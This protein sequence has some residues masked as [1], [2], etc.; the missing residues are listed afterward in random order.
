MLALVDGARDR[1]VDFSYDTYPYPAGST[2]LFI[3]LP[4]W[5]HDGGPE[6]LLQRLSS[7][8]DRNRLLDEMREPGSPYALWP[9]D[10]VRISSVSSDRNRWMEGLFLNEIAEKVGKD[11]DEQALDMLVQENLGISA[12]V[13]RGSEPDLQEMMRHPSQMCST[14]ALLMGSH[15]HPRGYG[16]Y[17]RFLGRYVRELGILKLEDAI[18]RMTSA[19]SA[20]FGLD[21]RGL[22]RVGY[23]ADILIFD[24]ETIVDTATFDSPR[25]FPTGIDYVIVN[26]TPVI[27]NGAHTHARVGRALRR[28]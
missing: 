28:T 16:T 5:A 25:R 21:D 15:P 17:P 22:L 23:A 24:P 19:P 13:M 9:P 4:N 8:T 18:R 7:E 27:E 1:G 10:I 11:P 26:G 20:R 12:I 6:M 2:G 14:D 3:T